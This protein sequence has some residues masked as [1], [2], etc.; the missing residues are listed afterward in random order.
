MLW[1]RKMPPSFSAFIGIIVAVILAMDLALCQNVDD[2]GGVDTGK[3]DNP[4][5][6]ELMTQEVNRRLANVTSLIFSSELAEKSSFCILD[7]EKDWNNAFNFSQD[8]RFLSDCVARTRGDVQ[9]RLCTAAEIRFY[10]SNMFMNSMSYLNPNRN[11]NLTSWISGCEPGWACSTGSNQNPDLRNLKD[12][13]ARTTDCQPCC[14]GFFCPHGITCMI[15]CPLGS[16]CP[17][18]RLNNNTGVC[19]PY[20]YQLPHRQSNHTCGGANIWAD[21]TSSS[22]IFCSAGSYCPSNTE[23]IRCSSGNYCPT[24]ST[25][26]K[27]CFKLTS[28]DPNTSSQN[29]HAYGVMLI[30]ALSTVLL[31]IY[32]CSDQIITIRERRRARSRESAAKSVKERVQAQARWKSAKDAVKKHAIELHSQVSLKLSRNKAVTVL[33]ETENDQDGDMHASNS[34][35]SMQSAASSDGTESEPSPYMKMMKDIGFDNSE[36]F[37]SEIKDKNLK[38]RVPKGKQAH[39]HSQMFKY[40]YAQLEKEKAQQQQNKSLT[41]SGVISMATN[42]EIR[43]RPTIEIAFRDLTVTLKGKNKHLLRSINGKVMP[44]RVT[45]VMGPS[46]AGKTTFLSALAGKTVGCTL[47]GSIFINGKTESIHSYRKI[48]GFVPQDDIVH[49]NLTVEENL[50]F[51]AKCRLSADLPEPDK[52]LI[53]ERVIDSLGLQAV[54]NSLVGTVEKRGISG[55]QRKRV[56]VGLEL[57]IEPSLL[58]LDEPTSGLDSASSQ[59]LLRALRREAL[60]GVNIC[61]VVHQ[62][63]YTLFKMFDDLI[64]LAKGG[65]TV[66]HGPAKKVEEYFAGL[67]INVPERVNPPDYFIDVLEGLIRPNASSNMSYNE[68]PV[69]WMVHNGYAVPPDMQQNCHKDA[70]LPTRVNINDHI[71]SGDINLEHSFAGEIWQ[72]MKCNVER[73]RDILHHNFLRSKDLSN[74]RTPSILLQ[75]KYFLGRVGKQRLREAKTQAMDYL[76]LLVAGAC[77]GSLTKVKDETFGSPGYV[78][79]IIAVSLLCKVAALRTFSLDKLQYWRESASGISSLAHFVS[80]DTID[81]F[82][83][84]IKPAVYLS[85]FYF[86]CNPRSSFTDNYII[87]LCLVYCVTGMGYALAIFLDSG[88]AQLCAVLVPVVLTLVATRPLG[89]KFFNTIADLCYP[90]W[91]LQGFVIANAE[92]YYGV[93]LIT[94][95]GALQTFGYDIHNWGLCIAILILTGLG[96]RIVA[97]VGMIVFQKK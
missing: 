15:P 22:E 54:R 14:E 68:L 45:A 37:D 61:M 8:L 31:I 23:R 84:L 40:A 73:H 11:C 89:S 12:I 20:N 41:F 43:K 53:V 4:A 56:N 39:T 80:K 30:V 97:F 58:F 90:K 76:I 5:V 82:N 16:Y 69:S 57:V 62:P 70:V 60:E 87:L 33:N 36:S 21:V 19:E 24:G 2:S 18:A 66:Y 81:H 77:L 26:E 7:K 92:R 65:L 78:H 91:A 75:Y 71:L 93:W 17:L 1:R 55:G 51:S 29:M 50:W 59:L 64:L 32:N 85:M 52:V 48:L 86:F 35:M 10:F 47:T 49:G 13:P 67:G 63:S 28:C 42:K 72:D 96:S 9:Q 88:P 74:R 27:R 95:C 25:A 34:M 46:G 79:T 6:R 38:T 44:G 3:I 94:R 83:T